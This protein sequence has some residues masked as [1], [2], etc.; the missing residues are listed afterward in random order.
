MISEE[1][2]TADHDSIIEGIQKKT[3]ALMSQQRLAFDYLNDIADQ[4][5]TWHF[6]QEAKNGSFNVLDN[7]DEEEQERPVQELILIDRSMGKLVMLVEKIDLLIEK[8]ERLLSKAVLKIKLE[9]LTQNCDSQLKSL[10]EQSEQAIK[11]EEKVRAHHETMK[12][13]TTDESLSASDKEDSQIAMHMASI[14][15]N[16]ID[17]IISSLGKKEKL[18]RQH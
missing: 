16:N 8:N 6:V 12:L 2:L 15:L 17:S 11:L 7:V 13:K 14:Q 10:Q 4:L 9:S 18:A 1:N 5:E 3:Q